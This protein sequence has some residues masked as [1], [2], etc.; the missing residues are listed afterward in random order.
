FTVHGICNGNPVRVSWRDGRLEGD[1]GLAKLLEAY[2]E[3]GEPIAT[4]PDGDVV[5][6][7]LTDPVKAFL[8]IVG[9]IPVV[10]ALEGDPPPGIDF[11]AELAELREDQQRQAQRGRGRARGWWRR[12]R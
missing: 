12:I 1:P 9:Q 4:T 5:E 10:T 2:A 11:A 6:A 7:D 8:L 3:A